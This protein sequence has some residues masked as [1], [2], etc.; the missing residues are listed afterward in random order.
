MDRLL[1]E[2]CCGGAGD[3]IAAEAAGADRVELNSSLGSGG[4]TPSAGEFLMAI[5]RLKIPVIC[6]IRP[7]AG[8]FCY[9]EAEFQAMLR[10]AAFF[11]EHGAAGIAFG[12]LHEDGRVDKPRCRRLMAELG[13]KQAV[14]H[15]AFD[16]SACDPMIM[17]DD[18]AELG[19]TRLLSSGR[20][21]SAADGA[22]LLKKVYERTN[23]SVELL[24]GGG[25]RPNN[26]AHIAAVTGCGQLHFSCHKLI[27]D[28][29]ALGNPE[30][31][32]DCAKP[33]FPGAASVI[34]CK[35]LEST[36]ELIK[37]SVNV[38]KY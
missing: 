29:S 10:D 32:F 2:I 20:R 5:E 27:E 3:A 7:R 13:T 35:K 36:I 38:N 28:K 22:Q 23:K 19:V 16:S 25:V 30:L 18:L 11:S 4:L 14:F 33:E 26:A 37:S 34:D 21:P 8:G 12:I 31:S 1:V 24:P 17:A 6:M 9:N 15:R